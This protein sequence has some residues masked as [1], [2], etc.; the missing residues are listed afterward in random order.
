MEFELFMPYEACIGPVFESVLFAA[1]FAA[2]FVMELAK[3][4]GWR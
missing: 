1:S 3:L 2:G 4:E